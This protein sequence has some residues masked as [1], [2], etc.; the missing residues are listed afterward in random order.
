LDSRCG[1][2]GGYLV[3]SPRNSRPRGSPRPSKCCGFFRRRSQWTLQ[4]LS[5][6]ISHGSFSSI[7]EIASGDWGMKM[8]Q[9]ESHKRSSRRSTC[10][11]S[12]GP[13]WAT[14]WGMVAGT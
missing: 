9:K 8:L 10:W 14:G 7:S 12:F 3:C 6:G 2:R 13:L 1:R 5:P 4:E 11:Q